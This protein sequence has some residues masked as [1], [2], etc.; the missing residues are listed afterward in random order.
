MLLVVRHHAERN[1]TNRLSCQARPAVLFLKGTFEILANTR[2][3]PRPPY[4]THSLGV[5]IFSEH[6]LPSKPLRLIKDACFLQVPGVLQQFK[7]REQKVVRH[8]SLF[9]TG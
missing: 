6:C 3:G 9:A 8:N 2:S 5:I 7:K 1:Q 4:P